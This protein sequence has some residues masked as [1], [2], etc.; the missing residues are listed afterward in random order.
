ME[1]L[2]RELHLMPS[3][4]KVVGAALV[5]PAGLLTE[6][7][8]GNGRPGTFASDP[9]AIRRVESL[10]MQAVIMT[11]LALGNVPR[12]V[13]K[14]NRGYDVESKGGQDGALRM[15]EVKGRVEGARSVT[16]TRNEIVTAMNRPDDYILAILEIAADSTREPRYVRRPFCKEP[17]FN[18]H[19]VNYDLAELLGR[20]ESPS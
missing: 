10:A 13:S 18:V 1:E 5:V 11:E 4:L 15:I 16:V 20:S 9:D 6:G 3:P 2:H 17:E 7:A 8:S 14:E 19:S 12:D